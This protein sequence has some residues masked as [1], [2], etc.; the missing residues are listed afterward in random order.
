MS[1]GSCGA[2]VWALLAMTVPPANA[3][4]AVSH[5]EHHAQAAA[6]SDNTLTEG[7]VRRIN[8]DDRKI[9]LRHGPIVNLDMPEMTMVFAVSDPAML[10]SVDV[11]VKVRFRAERREGQLTITHL[12]ALK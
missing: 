2:L 3:Q 4:S 12:E 5:S 7:E 1:I 6:P 9:T 10:E 11:G 8:R